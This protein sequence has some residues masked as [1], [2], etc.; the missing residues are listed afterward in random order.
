MV[1]GWLYGVAAPRARLHEIA[2]D[3]AI[4]TLLKRE[5]GDLSSGQKTRVALAKALL[6]KPQLLLL[7]EPTASLDPDTADWIRSYLQNYQRQSGA[8]ILLASHNMTEVERLCDGV[9]IMKSGRIVDRGSPTEL[10][11]RYG[12]HSMEEVFLHIARHPD[13]VVAP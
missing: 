12:R 13:A 8:T 7:D 6:N 9:L 10:I 5:L 11:A 3:L 1:Y 2:K 4:D